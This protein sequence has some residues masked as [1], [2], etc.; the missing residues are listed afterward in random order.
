MRVCVCVCAVASTQ[1]HRAEM[2]AIIDEV[3]DYHSAPA[4]NAEG[5]AGDGAA[6]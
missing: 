2:K 4:E 1:V 3:F 5:S 6:P